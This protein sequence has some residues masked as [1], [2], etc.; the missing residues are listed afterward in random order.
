MQC[1]HKSIFGVLLDEYDD[2]IEDWVITSDY[3]Q[4]MPYFYVYE[5]LKEDPRFKGKYNRMAEL[6]GKL[7]IL[8]YMFNS[9]RKIMIGVK[10]VYTKYK[11]HKF[12][13]FIP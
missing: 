11:P 1:Y 12:I 7:S 4:I 2:I 13:E 5:G 6:I 8:L 10:T 3:I 9:S